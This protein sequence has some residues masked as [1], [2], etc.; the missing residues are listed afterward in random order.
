[1]AGGSAPAR[2]GRPAGSRHRRAHPGVRLHAAGRRW[3]ADRLRPAPV[4]LL[5]RG[6][7]S[8][9]RR[10]LRPQAH[11]P[12]SS[13]GGHGHGPP[14]D[15]SGGPERPRPGGCRRRRLHPRGG[16]HRPP[17]RHFRRGDLHPLRRLRQRG[18]VLR[19]KSAGSVHGGA[20]RLEGARPGVRGAPCRQQRG[21]VRAPGSPPGSGPSGH[22]ALRA[23]T[24]GRE[25]TWP[26]SPC[27]RPWR[28]RRASST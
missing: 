14:R 19:Q 5:P 23:Q 17:A 13:Q 11:A 12:G 2:G 21:L 25:S 10:R 16:R 28:S 4:G 27:S 26:A 24:F 8:L 7:P 20:V 3:P 15:G 9:F 6:G 18:S 1:M 22:R